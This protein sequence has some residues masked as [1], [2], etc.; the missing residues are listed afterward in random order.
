MKTI[1]LTVFATVIF[2]GSAI[3]Q[4]SVCS[5]FKG[6]TTTSYPYT[7]CNF[8]AYLMKDGVKIARFTG[9][10]YC[11]HNTAV[12]KANEEGKKLEE[13]GVCVFIPRGLGP[14]D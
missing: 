7:E 10:N 8:I 5:V 9:F 2:A 13:A 12:K 4:N 3:A 14:R 1:F 6:E 11:N